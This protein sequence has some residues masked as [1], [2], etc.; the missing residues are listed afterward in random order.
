MEKLTD[1][2]FEIDGVSFIEIKGLIVSFDEHTEG[3]YAF[4]VWDKK[5]FDKN[6]YEEDFSVTLEKA[7]DGGISTDAENTEEAIKFFLSDLGY[8]EQMVKLAASNNPPI[9]DKQAGMDEVFALVDKVEAIS[10][11]E[12]V[13]QNKINKR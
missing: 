12:D 9:E 2:K 3:G 1:D 13:E 6:E 8:I 11:C 5:D 4:D 7:L 10:D